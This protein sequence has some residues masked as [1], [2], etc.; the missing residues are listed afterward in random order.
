MRSLLFG[1]VLVLAA[2]LALAVYI[3]FEPTVD[4]ERPTLAS[5]RIEPPEATASANAAPRSQPPVAPAP[6]AAQAERPAPRPSPVTPTPTATPGASSPEIIVTTGL[7]QSE[8][9]ASGLQAPP[10]GTTNAAPNPSRPTTVTIAP[11]PTPATQPRNL[12]LPAGVS[13]SGFD[14]ITVSIPPS[15]N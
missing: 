13:I 3:S 7:R 14:G 4:A 9:A 5:A 2:A 12:D 6:S 10:A 15:T 1:T 11:A 8:P